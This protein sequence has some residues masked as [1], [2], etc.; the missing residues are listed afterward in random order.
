MSPCPLKTPFDL[1]FPHFLPASLSL[2]CDFSVLLKC[3]FHGRDHSL[4]GIFTV[5]YS[6]THGEHIIFSNK[7]GCQLDLT[8]VKMF[9][10]A[11]FSGGSSDNPDSFVKSSSSQVKFSFIVI[12]LHVWTHS[13]MKCR[14]SHAI[15]KSGSL[16]I[17]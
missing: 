12:P 8:C 14:A 5:A 2:S 10:G 4:T 13:G 11:F 6:Y 15:Y 1:L 3:T 16:Y 17:N 9:A 7:Y